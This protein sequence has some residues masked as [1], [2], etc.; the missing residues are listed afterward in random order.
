[1]HKLPH[2]GSFYIQGHFSL[3]N[4]K[5]KLETKQVAIMEKLKQKY[6]QD[7]TFTTHSNPDQSKHL[8]IARMRIFDVWIDF[9]NL[10]SETYAERICTRMGRVRENKTQR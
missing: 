2:I 8:E 9:V 1:M 10:R 6:Y 3:S 5:F 4:M 7:L